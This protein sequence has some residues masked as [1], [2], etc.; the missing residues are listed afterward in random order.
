MRVFNITLYLKAI[1]D[2]PSLEVLHERAL[3]RGATKTRF[4]SIALYPEVKGRL[5]DKTEINWGEP[6][7]EQRA[8][9][10]KAFG[11]MRGKKMMVLDRLMGKS[12]TYSCRLIISADYPQIALM[13]A[14][15]LNP[16]P[17]VIPN[18]LT[19]SIP[20]FPRPHIYVFPNHNSPLVILL[21]VDYGGEHKMA[22]LKQFLYQTKKNSQSPGLGLHAASTSFFV[23]N[24]EKKLTQKN[25]I[26]LA[27]S[28][29]GKSSLSSHPYGL[30]SPEKTLFR[31]DDI[32][33]WKRDGKIL[34]TEGRAFY[35]MVAELQRKD[36]PNIWT[37]TGSPDAI[38]ENTA[39][40]KIGIPDFD[41][42]TISRNS[43]ASIPLK[44]IKN[45]TADID[46]DN[47][48]F[49]FLIAR[50]FDILPPVMRL[51]AERAAYEFMC[52][53]TVQ[54]SATSGSKLDEVKRTVGFNPFIMGPGAQDRVLAE[55]GN[56]FLELVR[57]NP[58]VQV[59]LINTGAIGGAK[60]D[61]SGDIKLKDTTSII[62]E[63]IRGHVRWKQ[64]KLFENNPS[65]GRS[66]GY[67][68]PV[69]I[70]G[71]RMSRFNPLTYY[72]PE[73]ITEIR[74]KMLKSD[75]EWLE[76]FRGKLDPSIINLLGEKP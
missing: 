60:D 45:A 41:D 31:Q 63:V 37:A 58:Q 22:F 67:E 21:G 30:K 1:E 24:K 13:W 8:E 17:L 54:T 53:R 66:M 69:A 12:E 64:S 27:E 73:Q 42:L 18:F 74:E 32:V 34:G 6:T 14:S 52:G 7:D 59:F 40:D 38:F 35:Y 71:V 4:K 26:F 15:L 51:S 33:N 36:Q 48:D 11:M 20:E 61:G 49:V 72:T 2:N 23:L 5:T 57:A 68:E 76:Q 3:E 28:G 10:T 55:E 39:I 44:D 43:R 65:G 47:L 56:L 46:M 25:A 9:I 75:R 19:I 50:Q 29:I 62:R 16:S 70:R